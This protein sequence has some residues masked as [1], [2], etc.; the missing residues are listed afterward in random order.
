M[1][2]QIAKAREVRN[3]AVVAKAV[4]PPY[5]TPCSG[6]SLFTGT[7]LPEELLLLLPDEDPLFDE[8]DDTCGSCD[9]TA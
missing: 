7:S 3:T 1:V 4:A 9:A 8:D 5:G 6:A 2:C